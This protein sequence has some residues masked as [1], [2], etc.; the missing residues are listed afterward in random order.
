[1]SCAL[2][3]HLCVAFL[4]EKEEAM[5]VEMTKV[6]IVKADDG[7]AR[8]AVAEGPQTLLPT[9][10]IL[11]E[12]LAE[13]KLTMNEDNIMALVKKDLRRM[14]SDLSSKGIQIELE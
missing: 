6:V 11:P 5:L 9:K 12:V 1:M 7:T 4:L 8:V 14:V 10:D 2:R 3:P 13:K